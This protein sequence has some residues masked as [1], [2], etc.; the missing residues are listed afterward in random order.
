MG[1]L[2]N[3]I[4]TV[5]PSG[6]S[7]D[8]ATIS[9]NTTVNGAFTSQGIDDNADANAITITS[10]EKVG[11]GV[12]AP[13]RRLVVGGQAEMSIQNNDMS[14][15]RRNFNFFLTGDKGHMRLLND[16]GNAGGTGAT[17]PDVGSAGG[18]G[19]GGVGANVP[20]AT[21]KEGSPGGLG[22]QLPSA[23]RNPASSIGYPGSS[24]TYWVAGGG[25][26]GSGSPTPANAGGGGGAPQI[27][28][29]KQGTNLPAPEA[30][31]YEWSGAG[32]GAQD[33]GSAARSAQVNSGSGGGG[34]GIGSGDLGLKGGNGGSGLVLIAYPT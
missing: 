27:P 4:T 10:D 32:S 13:N 1:Y 5:F 9:G 24:E 28:G 29:P 26:G 21:D 8:T 31:T 30:P 3:Q 2:G 22:I 11:I 25:G 34:A 15:D 6:L 19:S 18:G 33:T 14:A 16:A 17:L 20:G 7:V 23:F 12:T